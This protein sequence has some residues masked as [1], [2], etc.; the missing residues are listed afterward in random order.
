MIKPAIIFAGMKLMDRLSKHLREVY[1][2]GNWTGANLKDT[3]ADVSWEEATSQVEDLNT[4]SALVYHIG[5][6][7][8]AVLGALRGE[9]LESSDEV[10]FDLPPIRSK[11]DWERLL[12]KTY[13][14]AESMASLL[15]TLPD[16]KLDEYIAEEKH[17]K[18]YR[19]LQG[20]LEHSH[21]HLGQ[22]ALIK[23]ILRQRNTE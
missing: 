15:E 20:I 23:K 3:L 18:Y 12:A 1:F 5:Y 7:V 10:S 16:S 8:T 11:A 19:S 21:Y 4:I 17:G 22:V 2:G 9:P 6:Y 14:D 13:Q